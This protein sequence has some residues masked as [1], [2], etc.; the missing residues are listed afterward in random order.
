MAVEAKPLFG[1]EGGGAGDMTLLEHLKELRNRVVVSAV[2][3]LLGTLVS[4]WFWETIVSWL[5]APARD[6]YDPNFGL[7]VF[8]PTETIGVL[9]KVGLYGG[10]ILASPVVIYELL[11][12]IVPGL[13]PGERKLLL[14]GLFGVAVFLL[15]G[16][17]FAYWII[18]PA[19]LG[20]LLDFGGDNFNPVIGAKQYMDFALR[21]IFWVGV[22]F[23]LPMV[24]A[25]AAKL[26]LVR[27]RQLIHFWRYAVIIIFIIAAVV[28]PT[29]DPLTQT[30]VAGPLLGLY[31]LGVLFAWALQPKG[32]PPEP[33]AKTEETAP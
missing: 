12:F 13:T 15:A 19:S 3:L 33:A 23:E 2:A 32:K 11:A 5:L 6:K 20:F 10:M 16:M 1:S 7:A 14:P 24:L 8:G 27:A 25:L 21:I 4:F 17:A 28:T 26:R 30:L 31:V 29:P 9:F 22:S 18:L